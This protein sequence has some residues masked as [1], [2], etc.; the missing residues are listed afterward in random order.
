[1]TTPDTEGSNGLHSHI[2]V[3][4]LIVFGVLFLAVG[5]N[6]VLLYPEL[7]GGTVALND[8]VLHLLLTNM[9]VDAI[10]HWRDVT[11]PWQGTMNMGF[12]FF[13]YYQHLPHVTVALVHVFTF[14][15]LPVIDLMKWTTYLLL[16]LFPLSIFWSLRRFGFDQLTAAMGG[17]VGSLASTD[18]LFGFG[19]TSYTFLGFGLYSQLW[20]MVLFPP[21]LALGYRVLRE[22]R[23][24]FWA[25]LLLAA[26]LMSH[27][28]YGYMA[29]ITLGVLTFIQ[30]NRVSDPESFAPAIWRQWRRLIILFLL[31]AVVTSYFLVPLFLDLPYVND[32]RLLLPI[33]RDSF[34][35]SVVLQALVE[36]DLFDFNRFPSLTILVL[37]GLGICLLRWREER[38]LIPVAI[39]LLWLLLYFGRSTWGPLMDLL[40]FSRYIHL[41]RFIAGVHLGG[42]LL[43]AIAL[44]AP[45]RWA[46][47]RTRVWYVA[48]AVAFSLLLLLPVY[49]ERRSY[50]SGNAFVIK[51]NQ[52]A[53][54]AEDQELSALFERL[55]QL[56]PGRVYAG[57]VGQIDQDRWG[58]DYRVGYVEVYALLY[59][60]GLDMMGDIYHH[61]SLPSDAVRT[62]DDSKLQQ[63]N[64][65]NV[66]YV[67]A[68][69]EQRFP[70]FVKPLQQFGRH[71]LYR[72][73]TTG[74]FDLVDSHLTFSGGRTDFRPAALSWMASELPGVKRHP[75]VLLGSSSQDIER[76]L[77]LSEASAVISKVQ[78][79][80]GSTRGEVLSEEVGSNF[81]AA[82]V[83]VERESMLLLK[84]TYHPNWRATVDGVEADTVMLIPGFMGVQLTPGNHKVRFEYQPRRLRMVLLVLGLLTLASIAVVEKRGTILSSWFS[85]G[86]LARISGSVKWPR[87]TRSRQSRRRRR[88]R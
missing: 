65:F 28:M 88:R 13:H 12:P 72:V 38:Y 63:Y 80:A 55:K 57:P 40:P 71:H 3:T 46:I 22:G 29:F 10:T 6:L 45:W 82:E 52:K 1:M 18:Q 7:T 81:Y 32:S 35:H 76:P 4:V 15:V 43:A 61:Y 9:A 8:G 59:A 41:H 17:L 84:V 69:E 49:A 30:L 24:Y 79:S 78:V 66:R 64:L 23:G 74:Y 2:P 56:P 83:K 37:A 5:F 21:A 26:T 70:A 62:F 39:F 47:S 58:L 44:A 36:G 75:L 67:I 19:Y 68:P 25:S 27:L 50:A 42:I 20:A 31:V 77:P 86:V 53:L 11:D 16:S 34:G 60:K 73:E 51:E 87:R 85:T 14:G 48:A 33:F 54:A